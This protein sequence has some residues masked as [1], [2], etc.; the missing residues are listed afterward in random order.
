MISEAWWG[1]GMENNRLLLDFFE[2]TNKKALDWLKD[3]QRL[4]TQSQN[5]LSVLYFHSDGVSDEDGSAI[6]GI[7]Q[8]SWIARRHDIMRAFPDLLVSDSYKIGSSGLQNRLWRV[9]GCP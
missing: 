1:I 3:N 7:K 5:V 2:S 4:N 8:T 9:S 6:L